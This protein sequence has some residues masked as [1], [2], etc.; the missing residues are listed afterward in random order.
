ME[1]NVWSRHISC[2]FVAAK[3]FIGNNTVVWDWITDYSKVYCDIPQITGSYLQTGYGCLLPSPYLLTCLADVAYQ[4][5][6]LVSPYS[7]KSKAIFIFNMLWPYTFSV[8]S[9]TSATINS[10]YTIIYFRTSRNLWIPF[11]QIFS[12]DYVS[13]VVLML[14]FSPCLAINK[15]FPHTNTVSSTSLHLPGVLHPQPLAIAACH[16]MVARTLWSP[17]SNQ[18]KSRLEGS[19]SWGLIPIIREGKVIAP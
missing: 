4:R 1:K 2:E 8:A 7:F 12:T 17:G 15:Q 14:L 13:P 16:C 3:C 19:I 18:S 9:K 11:P 10:G 5:I 6:I